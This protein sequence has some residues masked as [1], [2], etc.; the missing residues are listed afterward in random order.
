VCA[1]YTGST[2]LLNVLTLPTVTHLQ[3]DELIL[4]VDFDPEDSIPLF[5]SFVSRIHDLRELRITNSRMS[6][7]FYEERIPASILKLEVDPPG[8]S[9]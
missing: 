8:S 3:L 9:P 7:S 4:Q 6:R 1:D 2:H 5:V